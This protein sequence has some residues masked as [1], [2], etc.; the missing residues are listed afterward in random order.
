MGQWCMQ[1]AAAGP[2]AE[3][4]D[5]LSALA[6]HVKALIDA[7]LMSVAESRAVCAPAYFDVLMSF[8]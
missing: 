4:E 8:M 3:R 1:D 7:Q 2:V 5:A 6:S